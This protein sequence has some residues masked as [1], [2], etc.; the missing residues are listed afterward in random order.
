LALALVASPALTVI[1]DAHA[2]LVGAG[3]HAHAAGSVTDGTREP[4][5]DSLLFALEHAS[6]CCSHVTADMPVA[7]LPALAWPL[8][9][10]LPLPASLP[11]DKRRAPLLRPPIA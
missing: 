9:E 6:H 5:P 4:A 7:A 8:R 2:A 1:G 11:L 3:Q 10:S